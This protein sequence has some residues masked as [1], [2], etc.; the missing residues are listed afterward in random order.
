MFSTLAFMKS[1]L[2]NRLN[3]HLDLVMHMFEQKF[4]TLGKEIYNDAIQLWK[5]AKVRHGY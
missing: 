5:A 4:Y 1:E 3:D 2:R